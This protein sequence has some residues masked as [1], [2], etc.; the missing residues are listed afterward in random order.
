MTQADFLAQEI[1]AP[2]VGYEGLYEVSSFGSVRSLPR[3]CWDGRCHRKI[4][5]KIIKSFPQRTGYLTVNLSK[6][7]QMTTRTVHSLVAEAFIA[8]RIGRQHCR[9]LDGDK[10]NNHLINLQ[11]GSAVENA[12]DKSAHGTNLIGEKIIRQN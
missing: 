6:E 4:K 7:G 9:H 11:W 8:P 10:T 3:T 5:G 1:W 2:I 12:K